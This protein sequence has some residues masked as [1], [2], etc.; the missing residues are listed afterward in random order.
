[1][2]VK[3]PKIR[4]Q[5]TRWVRGCEFLVEV[6]LGDGQTADVELERLKRVMDKV[7]GEVTDG[8]GE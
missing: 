6:E 2:T 7:F 5:A 3:K 4:V 8:D 1:M